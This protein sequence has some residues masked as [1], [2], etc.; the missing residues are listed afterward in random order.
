MNCVIW[1]ITFANLCLYDV[2]NQKLEPR[3]NFEGKTCVT[4]FNL[5]HLTHHIS[6]YTLPYHQCT[7]VK[8]KTG[9]FFIAKEKSEHRLL[10]KRIEYYET[11]YSYN[12]LNTRE[13]C[14]HICETNNSSL[15][16][17]N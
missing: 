3:N 2:K 13:I 9:K 4:I 7:T 1:L 5:E 15:R 8:H 10:A 17:F 11:I 12:V 14:S 6:V 16:R